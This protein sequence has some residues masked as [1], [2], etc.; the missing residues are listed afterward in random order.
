ME[1][2]PPLHLG[3]VAIE[4]EA[5]RS[6]LTKVANFLLTLPEKNLVSVVRVHLLLYCFI[7]V[8]VTV[9]GNIL[10]EQSSN[11]QQGFMRLNLW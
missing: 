1:L 8:T 11:P 6:I 7:T 2:C 4:K 10:G 3:V 9:I 5:S